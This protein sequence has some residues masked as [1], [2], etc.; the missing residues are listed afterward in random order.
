ML[1][2]PSRVR[3]ATVLP[4][5]L[6]AGALALAAVVVD[7]RGADEPNALFRIE[8]F[9]RAG[10]T[11]WSTA[12]YGGHLTPAYSVLLPPLG[13]LLGLGGVGA[14][15]AVLAAVSFAGLLRSVPG[16]VTSRARIAS[17]LFAAGTLVNVA[18][19]RLAFAIG[20]ALGLTALLAALRRWRV[21][22]LVLSLATP[23][24]SPVA[25]VF[26]VLA[27]LAAAA[28]SWGRRTTPWPTLG[29][30][31]VTSAPLAV[32]AGAFSQGG[33]FPYRPAALAITLVACAAT[34]WLPA[35]LRAI[36]LGAALYAAAATLTFVV[37]NPLGANVTRLGMFVLAPLL[38]AAAP[39]SRRVLAV[40]V[41]P[42]LWWQW[43]P[44]A[45][46]V[47]R[48]RGDPSTERAYYEPLLAE[49]QRLEPPARRIEI[50]LT[51][52]HFEVAFVAPTVPIARGGERQLD[53]ADNG[54]FYRQEPLTPEAYRRW[55]V[56]HG[57]GY[58]ALADAPLDDSA[59]EEAALLRR[60]LA[61]L[62]PV[63][64]GGHWQ[65]WRV[66]DGGDLVEGPAQLVRQTPET[67]VLKA[68]ATGS[69]VVR[70][71]ASSLW[72]VDGDACVRHTDDE[73]VHL[74]VRAPGPL[75]LRPVV[76]GHRA[77][78]AD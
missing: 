26:L 43:S 13:A 37:P 63:W 78:C 68:W 23:L 62:T 18:I 22:A 11:V 1:A 54:V 58:V 71:H 19:G 61:F 40:A 10:F 38:I 67:V 35:S 15:S 25:G 33:R 20:L 66:V 21:V 76:W 70:V 55:L 34:R 30:A 64:Q 74:E 17:L 51:F 6:V 3:T 36:R 39:L 9:R 42:L 7:W 8:L 45:D 27:W 44:A 65:L 60:G 29:L 47:L 16:V 32:L 50:P 56:D 53:I 28:Q 12:W 5:A 75:V 48:S 57:V 31:V 2:I 59:E 69:V 52:R 14:A 4:A 72:S 73:W 49:L 46:A 77:F 24:A 41:V